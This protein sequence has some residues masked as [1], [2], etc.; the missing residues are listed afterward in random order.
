MQDT[1]KKRHRSVFGVYASHTLKYPELFF[2]VVVCGLIMQATYLIAPLY[3]K[4]FINILATGTPT[5]A[6]VHS[7]LIILA[8][9]VVVW[10]VDF[11]A[12]RIQYVA[13]MYL[14][15][16]VMKDLYHASFD[17]LLGHS[18]NFFTSQFAGSLTHRMSRFSK[19]YEML[20]D[21]L[22]NNFL[23]T[24]LF[25]SGAIVILFIR[26]HTLGIILAVWAILFLAFQ[27]YV[28]RKRLPIRAARAAAESRITG[29]LADAISN[30][31]TV[32][33]FSGHEHEAERFRTT[34]HEWILL[35][36]RAWLADAWIWMGIGLLMISVQA[37]LLY[38]GIRLWQQG[39][40]TAGD[41]I[42][43]QAYLLTAFERLEKINRDLR[44]VNDAYSDAREMIDILDTPHEVRDMPDAQSLSVSNGKIEFKNMSFFYNADQ[45]IFHDFN[46]SIAPGEKV[47]LVGKS[48]AGKST[49]IKLILRLFDVKSGS[50]EIDNQN[51]TAVSQESLRDRIAFVPQ[52]PILFHRT[53]M[54]N[55][56]YG[57]LDASDNEVIMAGKRARC[58]EFIMSL[59]H[60]YDTYVGERGIKLSGGERQ[61]VA[62]ARAILK[63]APILILDEATSSLDSTSELL[64]QAALAELMQ[65]KTVIVI[66]HRLS[67]IMKMDRIV[68]L[69]KGKIIEEGTHKELLERNGRY[70][71]L[72]HHQAGGFLADE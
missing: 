28:A 26:N 39:L 55:I 59:P 53:L 10:F 22:M 32:A 30:Q 20:F 63:N 15:L 70:A 66:A 56:R 36:K 29:N 51:I 31:S 48:G 41:F 5:D 65:G 7:L 45:T 11:V 52:E 44:R 47:A 72:W 13:T 43:I 4:K 18:Y 9:V 37:A 19:V 14:E 57:R 54:E 71:E 61:R 24:L 40:F 42:L 21:A 34:V 62:I 58:H 23:P 50:I 6:A 67:T 16:R 2:T 68:V 46:L 3:L 33:L 17:Y 27:V 35:A 60:T 49:I 69:E 38:V 25:I 8:T 64:I 12:H 1:P